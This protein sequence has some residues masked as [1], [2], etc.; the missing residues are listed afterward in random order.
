MNSYLL[1]LQD[2]IIIC[3]EL[4]IQYAGGFFIDI[5]MTPHT[6]LLYQSDLKSKKNVFM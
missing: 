1:S 2:F 6:I 4:K 5:E 3:A